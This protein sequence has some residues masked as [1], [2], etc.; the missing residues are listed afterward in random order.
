MQASHVHQFSGTHRIPSSKMASLVSMWLHPTCQESK[1]QQLEQQLNTA[2]SKLLISEQSL[3]AMKEKNQQLQQELAAV[4]QQLSDQQCSSQEALSKAV[5]AH[6]QELQQAV[7]A[8]TAKEQ[9]TAAAA[10]AVVNQEA[11]AVGIRLKEE[12]QELQNKVLELK[13]Q[14][15]GALK[16]VEELEGR[17]LEE[18]AQAQQ[19][20]QKLEEELQHRYLGSTTSNCL[21]CRG[22]IRVDL[23]ATLNAVPN[24]D[25][26]IT[27]KQFTDT[28][29][30]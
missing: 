13:Q 14:L 1:L 19:Q 18:R 12:V 9:Q 24:K 26:S 11:A 4:H 10:V 17:L 27:A 28:W 15:D 3:R 5:A 21:N 30:R 22:I 25:A 23:S 7:A 20:V 8:A 2:L 16:E 6:E 29:K